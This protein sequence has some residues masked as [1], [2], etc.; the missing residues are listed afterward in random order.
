M[1]LFPVTLNFNPREPRQRRLAGIWPGMLDFFTFKTAAVFL[2]CY[3]G[4]YSLCLRSSR[5]DYNLERCITA[6]TRSQDSALLSQVFKMKRKTLNSVPILRASSKRL[7][8]RA[9]GR[10]GAG[11]Q[12]WALIKERS[13]APDSESLTSKFFPDEI[14]DFWAGELTAL[15]RALR[16]LEKRTKQKHILQQR[17]F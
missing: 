13:W 17:D 10:V 9:F 14:I 11:E 6:M 16:I 4:I 3:K 5:L 15:L 7:P 1:S 8:R 12:L 2:K